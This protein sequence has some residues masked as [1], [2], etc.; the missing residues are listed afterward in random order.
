MATGTELVVPF[1]GERYRATGRLSQLIAPPYDVIRPDQRAAYA[2]RDEHNI[3]HVMLPEASAAA[4]KYRH[5]AALLAAWR[6]A[7]VLERDPDPGVYVMSQTFALPSGQ[8]RTRTGLFGAV[9]AE[10]YQPG[11]IRPHERTHRAPKVDR[12]ALLRATRTSLESIF[13]IARDERG[14]LAAALARITAQAPH[15]T[16]TLDGTELRLWS[17]AGDPSPLPLPPAPLYI[18]DGHHRFETASAHAA[19]RRDASRLLAFVVSAQDPG[20]VVLPTHR[21]IFGAGRTSLGHLLGEWQQQFEIESL[22]P[23]GDP[24]QRLAQVGDRTACVVMTPGGQEF[25]LRLRPDADLSALEAAEPDRLVRALAVTRIEHLVVRRIIGA[26]E[27]T[28]SLDNTADPGKAVSVVR[29]GRAA[30]VAV[31]TQPTALE[32]VL[33]VADA[34]GVMPPKSTYFMP[35]VPSGMVLLPHT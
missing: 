10:G 27:S 2:A 29:Q 4:D 31:L 35:K 14:N 22:T 13:L 9:A 23:A 19:E 15:V 11:R 17:V 16:T 25:L 34:G 28:V 5:A 26:A 24:M 7:G 30:A 18:A 8:Q 20:L 6:E 1:R 32:Q 12:L 21:V 33:A 3:V